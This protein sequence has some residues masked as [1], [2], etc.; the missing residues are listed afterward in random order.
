MATKGEPVSLVA[1]HDEYSMWFDLI[2][3][4]PE[5]PLPMPQPQPGLQM[6]MSRC[7]L[8][9]PTCLSSIVTPVLLIQ[10]SP[11]L[12]DLQEST[13][14]GQLCLPQRPLCCYSL[15]VDQQSRAKDGQKR[16]NGKFQPN[17]EGGRGQRLHDPLSGRTV[18]SGTIGCE[19][20]C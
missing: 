18:S 16:R 13:W 3:S 11:M 4:N 1:C 20:G 19:A 17:G 6:A 14:S 9:T 12:K 8:P 7:P 15:K 10:S 2:L 5:V